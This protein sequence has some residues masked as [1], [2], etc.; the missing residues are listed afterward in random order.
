MS[1]RVVAIIN[2][3]AGTPARDSIED[4]LTQVFGSADLQARIVLAHGGTQI[5][6]LARAAVREKPDII[7]AGGGD[8]TV[9][10]IAAET[11]DTDIALGVL[12]LGTLNHFAKALKLPPDTQAAARVAISGNAI[13]V[14]VGEVNGRL[15]L[16]NSSLGLYPSLVR[17]RD[18]QQEQLGRGKWAA[19]T[20]AAVTLLRRHAL[21]DVRI[22]LDGARIQRRTAI[23][24][25][26]NN[27][28]EMCGLRV[29]ERLR[30]DAGQLGLYLPHHGGRRGLFM[31]G[32]RALCG[33]LREA[34]DFDA[35]FAT[36][37]EIATRHERLPVSLDGEVILL[38]APLHY[39]VRPR[40]LR[41]IVPAPAPMAADG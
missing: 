9:N 4:E 26:G 39:R 7:I 13:Q 6:D 15:F 14:D 18:R 11:V 10:A 5:R 29:G 37:I 16:N 25:V 19:A 8:G 32:L 12:P 28:Y 2:A 23:V 35:L 40:A 22:E 21:L 31:L 20:W 38:D 34:R 24:F 17:R 3:S 33:R 41:V 30:L 36:A 1:R 27:A